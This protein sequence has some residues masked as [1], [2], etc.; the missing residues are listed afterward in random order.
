MPKR[1]ETHRDNTHWAS[2]A[3]TQRAQAQITWCKWMDDGMT[4]TQVS[5]LAYSSRKTWYPH[6]NQWS[7]ISLRE[8]SRI[9]PQEITLTNHIQ[10]E[11]PNSTIAKLIYTNTTNMS[12]ICLITAGIK[13]A[14]VQCLSWNR[15]Q[16]AGQCG[17]EV[18]Q[19][20]SSHV[21][22]RNRANFCTQIYHPPYHIQ[23]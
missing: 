12:N 16:Y 15:R 9:V 22:G 2:S 21:L 10:A 18:I 11:W 7:M 5:G 4:Q 13:D 19:I 23:G 20:D 3:E 1:R 14:P 6:S 17:S 8:H